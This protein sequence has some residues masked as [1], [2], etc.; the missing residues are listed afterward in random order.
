MR[1]SIREEMALARFDSRLWAEDTPVVKPYDEDRWS[2]LADAQTAPITMSLDLLDAL[3]R[4]WVVFLKGLT[5][6][7]FRRQF[8]HPEHGPLALDQVLAM[9]AWHGPHHVAHVRNALGRSA[10]V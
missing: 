4:R 6:E 7:E 10:K 5:P 2:K 1:V 3:H 9:Y 8:V